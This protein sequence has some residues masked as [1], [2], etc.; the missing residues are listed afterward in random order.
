LTVHHGTA[1]TVA[2]VV[3]SGERYAQL[4]LAEPIVAARG[5]HVVLRTD[6]T[7]GGGLVL[8]PAPLRAVDPERLALLERGDPVSIVRALVEAP[9]RKE[10]LAARAVLDESALVAGLAEMRVEGG[11]VFSPSWLA[12][13]QAGVE[14]RLRRRAESSPLDPGLALAELLSPE[15]WAPVVLP[16]LALERRGGKAYLPGTAASLGDRAAAAELLQRELAAAGCAAVKVEDRALARYL[17]EA[18][19]LVRLGDGFA[20]GVG[21]YDVARDVLAAECASAGS[22]SLARFRDLL[23]VGRRDAQ[24]LLERFDADGLTRRAGDTRVLRRGGARTG[25]A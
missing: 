10:S 4:R 20:I 17:E 12:A 6:T 1:R 8:D 11:W 9:V 22:I 18:G 7:V 19:A 24:L 16:L 13:T 21:G 25:T 5:D 3:R 2:R 15:A 23:G 14:E